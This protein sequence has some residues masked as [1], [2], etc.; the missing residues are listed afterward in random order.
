MSKV[1]DVGILKWIFFLKYSIV[2][3][4]SFWSV[5]SRKSRLRLI[6]RL[7]FFSCPECYSGLVALNRS[8]K[9]R[10]LWFSLYSVLN[11]ISFNVAVLVYLKMAELRSSQTNRETELPHL[12]WPSLQRTSVLLV[13]ERKISWLQIQKILFLTRNG[14]SVG[15]GM[16][17]LFKATSS[18]SHSKLSKRTRSHTFRFRW[19][20]NRKHL[21]LRKSVLWF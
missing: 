16:I 3:L 21:Q 2:F 14:W 12:T 9:L 19:R 4:L 13:M 10:N 11:Y 8:C 18:S 20:E 1:T 17:K 15:H 7:N 6:L 5:Q